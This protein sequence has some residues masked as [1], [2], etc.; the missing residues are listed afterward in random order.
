MSLTAGVASHIITPYVGI[1][2]EGN[3]REEGSRGVHDDLTARAL[4]LSNG[5]D[6][7]AL[8]V[9][10]ICML[11]GWMATRI[12]ELVAQQ[13]GLQPHQVLTAAIH[14][15]AGPITVGIFGE[16][17]DETLLR[18]VAALAAGAVAEAF[19]NQV[20]ARIGWGRGRAEEPVNNRRLIARDGRLH[21]NWEGLDPADVVQVLGPT[22][23]EIGLVRVD[24]AD[25]RRL[26]TLLNYALHPAILAG[27]N[28]LISADWPSYAR[29]VV[30]QLHGGT[31]LFFNGATGNVNHINHRRPEQQRGFYEARRLGT[32]VGAAAVQGLLQIERLHDDIALGSRSRVLTV[33]GR[34]VSPEQVAAAEAIMAAHT[35]PLVEAATDGASD[36]LFASEALKLAARGEF[37]ERVEVQA[38]RLGQAA[39]IALPVELFVDYQLRFKRESPLPHSLLIGYANDYLGYVPTPEALQQGGYEAQPMSWSKL[40]PTAGDTLIATGLEL[41]SELC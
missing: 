25:G 12:R 18:Q 7:V 16:A 2:M 38:V 36:A 14:T 15:H 30:E 28:W 10:D 21:M 27:D 1:G 37:A 8:V 39:V 26:A 6:T 9:L 34:R 31:A 24:T 32:I 17:P 4:V 35:G 5:Q 13:T 33:A 11:P 22:D 20:P 40:G 3:A 41:L 19:R 29:R 23:P